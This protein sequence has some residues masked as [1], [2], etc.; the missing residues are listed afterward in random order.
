M[1][2]S[3]VSARAVWASSRRITV[4]LITTSEDGADTLLR[5]GIH[6]VDPAVIHAG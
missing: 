2:S 3:T 6:H 1:R 4:T 5:P